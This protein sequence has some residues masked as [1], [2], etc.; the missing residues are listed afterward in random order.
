MDIVLVLFIVIGILILGAI[1]Y[2][3]LVVHNRM[4]LLANNLGL[5][6]KFSNF[7]LISN[8]SFVV[9][10]NYKNHLIEIYSWSIEEGFFPTIPM[11]WT[12]KVDGKKLDHTLS[13]NSYMHTQEIANLLDKYIENE[14]K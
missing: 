4:K 8:R 1:T 12:I 3:T 7:S 10:G 11:N 13:A 14:L 5:N 2:V 6:Y 9:N